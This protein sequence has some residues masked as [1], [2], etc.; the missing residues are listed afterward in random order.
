MQAF[1]D[2][3]TPSIESVS[4]Y[5]GGYT[6]PTFTPRRGTVA[7]QRAPGEWT[8]ANQ[9]E[10]VA[11]GPVLTPRLWDCDLGGQALT[12]A[13]LAARLERDGFV[14]TESIP[15]RLEGTTLRCRRE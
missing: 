10:R 5:T 1:L 8:P 4:I 6:Y 14:A 11:I 15:H 12:D 2:M 7:F 9:T 13:E 3:L